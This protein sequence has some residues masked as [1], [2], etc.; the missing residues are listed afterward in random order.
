MA[1]TKKPPAKP[2]PPEV[3]EARLLAAARELAQLYIDPAVALETAVREEKVVVEV[4]RRLR[5][6]FTDE[7]VADFVRDHPHEWAAPSV[8]DAIQELRD[9]YSWMRGG[10]MLQGNFEEVSHREE[11]ARKAL[12]RIARQIASPKPFPDEKAGRRMKADLDAFKLKQRVETL[13]PGRTK[14]EA[15]AA[16]AYSLGLRGHVSPKEKGVRAGVTASSSVAKRLA[17]SKPPKK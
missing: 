15:Y 10:R 13:S 17:R 12:A 9:I 2:A 3:D 11:S 7:D 5:R 4:E 16:A 14:K 6:R 1:R 8:L